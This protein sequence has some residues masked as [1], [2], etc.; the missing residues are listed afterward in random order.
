WETSSWPSWQLI[1]SRNGGAHARQPWEKGSA[2]SAIS[3]VSTSLQK[4]IAG[5]HIRTDFALLPDLLWRRA[6]MDVPPGGWIEESR[7]P[8]PI[9]APRTRRVADRQPPWI[10]SRHPVFADNPKQ[11]RHDVH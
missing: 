8:M 3:S 1:R 11:C 10:S 9:D 5:R 7:I 6:E 2:P 4:V